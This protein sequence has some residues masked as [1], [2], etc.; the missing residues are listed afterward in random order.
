[1][2]LSFYGLQKKPFQVS[3]DPAFDNVVKKGKLVVGTYPSL[4]PLTS[5]DEKGNYVGHDIDLINRIAE[6]MGVE[7]EFKEVFFPELFMQSCA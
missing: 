4:E 1:M 6:E 7:L 5:F 3:T 2:Y